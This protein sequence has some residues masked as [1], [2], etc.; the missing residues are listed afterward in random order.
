MADAEV[1]AP[2]A[3][4][5]TTLSAGP[6][7]GPLARLGRVRDMLDQP[8][9]RRSMPMLG[10]VG[11]VG[12]AA[13]AWWSFQS[14]PQRSLFDGLAE[15]DKAA[16]VDALQTAGIN[17]QLSSETG[18]VQ[19]GEDDL[20]RARM[21]LA[22]Q[23]LPKAAPA[24]DALL[25]NIPMG[26][27]RALEDQGLRA[28]READ[29]ARTIEA[30]DAVKTARL[31]L[32]QAEAGPFVRDNRPPAAS[33]MLTM[34]PGRVLSPAQVRAIRQLVASS[35]T[36][37]SADAVS[38]VDQSGELMSA[39]ADEAANPNL[40]LQLDTEE[41]L[42][43]ALA[44]LLTPIVGRDS[45]SAEVHA[46]I[47]VS[48][49]QS[50]RES[51]PQ[52]D[53]ALRSEQGNKS[54]GPASTQAGG[55][56]GALANQ[57]PPPSQ[58]TATPPGQPAAGGPSAE[59]NETFAR[60]FD[61][62]REISVTHQPHGRLRRVSVA[63]AIRDLPGGK[64]RSAPEMAKLEALVK[65]AIGADPARGDLVVVTSRPFVEVTRED[66]ALWDRPWFM[67]LARQLGALFAALLAFLFLGRPLIKALRR[68]A[69]APA[70]DTAGGANPATVPAPVTLGM[71]AGA[72]SYEQRA[73]LVRDFVRQD[74]AKAS[75]VVKQMVSGHGR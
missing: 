64:Q 54:I 25:S 66:V 60:S 59:T 75:A 22:G 6:R 7:M 72:P 8:A 26:A 53:R 71:I 30:I 69:E 9:V 10:T 43:S 56:P 74:P 68:R 18:A 70:Q 16:V 48:E 5:P 21:L 49:S 36:G 28:A 62:G 34:Q 24:G 67:P 14:P 40:Q 47:D 38:V 73:G 4:V 42:R 37:L 20:H 58:L 19:V 11:A 33:V 3:L 51:Y 17:Y 41:R 13:L 50:T 23:G 46:D 1:L 39:R 15:A 57:P 29:L 12:L 44:T 61:V 65:G 2:G 35:V 32:A 52:N 27:S 45:F 63:V 31:H 55:I